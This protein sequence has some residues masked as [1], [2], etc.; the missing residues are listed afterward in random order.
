L[1][2]T[3]YYFKPRISTVFPKC[4]LPIIMKATDA[5]NL[6]INITPYQVMFGSVCQ[7]LLQP[8][9]FVLMGDVVSFLPFV[10]L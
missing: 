6:E 3:N 1:A 5:D 8:T 9:N 2:E 4:S 7:Q 10:K